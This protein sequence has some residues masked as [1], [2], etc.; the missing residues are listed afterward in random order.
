MIVESIQKSDIDIRRELFSN[1]ILTG[2]TTMMKGFSERIQ[3]H[4]PDIS[5][6]NIRVKVLSSNERRFQPWVGGSILSSL[7]S[8]QQMWMSRYEYEEH[9]SIMIERKCP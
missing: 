8:F 7:G 5:P 1:I 3:K 6:Q 9:G 2:G 4:L